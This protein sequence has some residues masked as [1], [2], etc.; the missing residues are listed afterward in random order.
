[1]RKSLLALSLFITLPINLVYGLAFDDLEA[2]PTNP[3]IKIP[4]GFYL[5]ISPG[6]S[7]HDSLTVVNNGESNM[8]IRVYATDSTINNQGEKVLKPYDEERSDLGTWIF[9]EGAAEQKFTLAPKE[10]KVLSFDIKIPE[11][12]EEKEYVGGVMVE[13]LNTKDKKLQ[14][15]IV[16]KTNSRLGLGTKVKVTSTPE[17]VPRIGNLEPSPD[18]RQTYF[19]VSLG[20]FVIAVGVL[21]AGYLRKKKHHKGKPHHSSQE[22][23]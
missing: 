4:G 7:G 16:I 12:T 23:K 15:S 8:D 5:E 9:F 6:Q 19:Y 2:N 20:L 14:D 10:S 18:W 1:M 11:D 22:K 13:K 3:N 21:G 17:T